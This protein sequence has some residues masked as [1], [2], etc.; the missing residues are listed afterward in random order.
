MAKS[1]NTISVWSGSVFVIA[2]QNN[3]TQ[4]SYIDV[5]TH[6]SQSEWVIVV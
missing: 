6:N 5:I 4:Y 1:K 3:T 2:S